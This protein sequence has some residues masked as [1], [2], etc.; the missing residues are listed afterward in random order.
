M[1]RDVNSFFITKRI[2][3]KYSRN[4][5]KNQELKEN[6]QQNNTSRLKFIENYSR[7][8][9]LVFETPYF[10]AATVQSTAQL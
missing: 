3:R 5:V 2:R 9:N 4:L 6:K 8:R 7:S 10:F 1:I